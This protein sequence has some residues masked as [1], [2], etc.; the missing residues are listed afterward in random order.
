MSSTAT[1]SQIAQIASQH[2]DLQLRDTAHDAESNRVYVPVYSRFGN[3]Q[4][5][6]MTVFLAYCGLVATTSTTS[7]L[8]AIP[9]I[10]DSFHIKAT[11]VSGS[12]AVCL[13]F[14][15]FSACFWGPWAD[16][17]GRKSAYLGSTA[18]FFL[19]SLGTALSQSLEAFFFFRALSACQGSAFLVLGSSS[20]SDIYHPTERATSLGW[21]LTGVM[22]G[23]AFGPILGGIIVTFTSWRVI[24]WLQMAMCGLALLM[25]LFVLQETLQQ[26]RFLELKGRGFRDISATFWQWTNPIGI[27]KLWGHKNLLCVSLASSALVWNM[28]SL[29]T[30]IRIV[31]NPRLNLTS[32]LESALLYIAPGAGYFVGT[33]IGGR[34][35]DRVVKPWV[36]KR[37]V[38]VPED[39]LRSSLVFMGVILPS[40]MLLY[41]LAVDQRIGIVPLPVICMFFHG[42]AQLAAFPSLN[43]YILDVMQRRSGQAS[44]SHYLM[45]YMFAGVST[46]SCLPMIDS[47]GV[48]WTSTIS[49]AMLFICAGL[50][51]LTIS[52]G[53]SW[54]EGPSSE[55]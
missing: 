46:A 47:I 20:I 38:R 30:P 32:P 18:L 31:L 22:V 4:K 29:L 11:I 42:V 8:T 33:L 50:V 17:F 37:G 41:G 13:L 1:I 26:P 10:V 3:A 15:G 53:K 49:S 40:S 28:Y 16:T 2:G 27:I 19:S 39:R 7:I 24:F 36:R 44:A 35:A 34:W 12:N 55:D 52:A 54:R 14:M 21:F 45:R 43:T 5:R 23:P 9:E 51:L 25:G 48:G 6:S